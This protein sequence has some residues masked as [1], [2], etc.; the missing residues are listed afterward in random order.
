MKDQQLQNVR[1]L[2]HDQNECVTVSR[3]VTQLH[4]SRSKASSLLREAIETDTNDAVTTSIKTTT[5][6][7]MEESSNEI[8]PCTGK[9]HETLGC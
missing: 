2:L 6:E 1:S 8:I 7:I 9:E 4:I 5:T 3:L